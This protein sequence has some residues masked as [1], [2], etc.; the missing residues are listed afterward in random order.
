MVLMDGGPSC[1]R[2]FALGREPFTSTSTTS[3]QVAWQVESMEKQSVTHN[4]DSPH[5]SCRGGRLV[6][7]ASRASVAC[8]SVEQARRD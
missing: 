8:D 6:R 1:R 4:C 5:S 7:A 3:L 2:G